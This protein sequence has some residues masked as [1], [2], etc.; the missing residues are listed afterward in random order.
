MGWVDSRA[1][2][3]QRLGAMTKSTCCINIS[4]IYMNKIFIILLCLYGEY[5]RPSRSLVLR[6]V[7]IPGPL[8]RLDVVIVTIDSHKLLSDN[9]WL[10]Q[11]TNISIAKGLF[12]NMDVISTQ[13]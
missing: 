8:G 12:V 10:D 1:F 4:A 7:L 5:T 11:R 2:K 9:E 13:A 6:V 3:A